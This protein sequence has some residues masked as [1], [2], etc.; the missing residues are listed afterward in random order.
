MV[1][2]Y[3]KSGDVTQDVQV[4]ALVT[5]INSDKWW[6][7]GVDRAIMRVA[8]GTFHAQAAKSELSDGKV[9]VAKQGKVIHFGSFKDVIFVVDD[10][11]SILSVLVYSALVE[12]RNQCYQSVSLPLMR[13]GVM[14][15]A[16]EPDVR[17]VVEQM[18]FAIRKFSEDYDYD[19]VIYI[20]VYNNPQ[21]VS[22]LLEDSSI[23]K[24]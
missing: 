17:A 2:V 5:L 11:Q 3:V 22:I 10:L 6:L 4:D 9:V 21:A 7:G 1:K 13:T 14:L 16:V 20:V 18:K 15:G 24:L 23:R 12:A 8:G 19:L